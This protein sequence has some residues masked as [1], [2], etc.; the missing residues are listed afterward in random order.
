VSHVASH[1][2][3]QYATQLWLVRH[4]RTPWAAA[5]RHTGRTD[6]S[7]DEVGRAEAKAVADRLAA[8]HFDRVLTSPLA[9]A[10]ETCQLAGLDDR[11]EVRDERM[12]WDYGELEG[13]T[14]SEIRVDLPG[15]T[16]WDGPVPGGETPDQVAARADVVI[17]EVGNS[18]LTVALFAHGHLL[19]VLAARWLHLAPDGGR[20][21]ALD[22]STVSVLGYEREQRVVLMWNQSCVE[23]PR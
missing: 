23:G 20:M 21:F 6:V 9:R 15:W 22:T 16:I 10:R 11:A 8:V 17:D 2:A 13:R 18:G 3:P 7:L 1:F 5:G 12:E 14:T 19:R 4:G